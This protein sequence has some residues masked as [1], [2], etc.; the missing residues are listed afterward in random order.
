MRERETYRD[1]RH[2]KLVSI[3]SGQ[4]W[5]TWLIQ[6][7]LKVLINSLFTGNNFAVHLHIFICTFSLGP[8]AWSSVLFIW[9]WHSCPYVCLEKSVLSKLSHYVWVKTTYVPEKQDWKPTSAIKT[10]VT[11]KRYLTINII[12]NWFILL[13][14]FRFYIE[15]TNLNEI[16]GHI[17]FGRDIYPYIFT[18]AIP[19]FTS[20]LIG[21]ITNYFGSFEAAVGVNLTILLV[22][23]T[24]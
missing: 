15:Q 5:Q 6:W 22:L 24:L 4:F 21:H 16:H 14:L 1:A 9:P 12:G 17:V 13:H 18:T 8:R 19:T 2:I 7:N 23:I 11:N 10:W 20:N 3:F